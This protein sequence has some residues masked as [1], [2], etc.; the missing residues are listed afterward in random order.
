[1]SISGSDDAKIF[2]LCWARISNS[3]TRVPKKGVRMPLSSA[4]SV[5]VLTQTFLFGKLGISGAPSVKNSVA[6]KNSRSR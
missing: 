2:E 3:C 4:T 1:M 5:K 6:G